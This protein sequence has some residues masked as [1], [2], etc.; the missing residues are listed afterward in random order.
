MFSYMFYRN[1]G[2]E[3]WAHHAANA[4]A[5]HLARH[6]ADG[7]HAAHLAQRVALRLLLLYRQVLLLLR[8]VQLRLFQSVS[9]SVS[10]SAGSVTA[11]DPTPGDRSTLL[12]NTIASLLL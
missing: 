4:R 9:Q 1:V 2:L 7:G 5:L 3:D 6:L 12:R 10:Q 11:H 8:L